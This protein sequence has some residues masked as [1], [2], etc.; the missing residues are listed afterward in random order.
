MGILQFVYPKKIDVWIV[1]S[2][3]L[4]TNHRRWFKFK[5][6]C[7][8]IFSYFM[9]K[10]I[11]GFVHQMVSVYLT[12]QDTTK[13]LSKM[14]VC[15]ESPPAVWVPGVPCPCQNMESLN[16]NHS[17][18]YVVVFHCGFIYISLITNDVECLFMVYLS[19]VYFLWYISYLNLLLIK[20]WCCWYSYYCIIKD[21][22]ILYLQVFC[23]MYALYIL[24]PRIWLAFFIFFTVSY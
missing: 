15:S 7:G 16:F 20:K 22:Y 19:R 2:W 3:W 8:Y 14:V 23:Q 11:K 17:N 12:L 9:N 1:P 24:S 4:W 21:F 5:S 10:Y 13:W 6:S 18:V